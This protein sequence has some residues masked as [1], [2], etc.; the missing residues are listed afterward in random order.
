MKL[1]L[2]PLSVNRTLLSLALLAALVAP[3]AVAAVPAVPGEALPFEGAAT[4]QET[5]EARC[6]VCHTRERVDAAM[7]AQKDLDTLLQHMIERGAILSDRD[8][9]VLGAF[10][11][12]PLKGE[13]PP[14]PPAR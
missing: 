8:R 6:T 5:V 13:S 14:A 4:F 7:R 9:K 10:W 2:I 12:S 1:T 3:S 11:G